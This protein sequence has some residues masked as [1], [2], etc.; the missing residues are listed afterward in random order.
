M[1][2]LLITG[3]A[4]VALSTTA[5]AGSCPSLVHKID[6]ALKTAQLSDADKASIMVM[7]NQGEEQH[8]A[9]QHAESVATLNAALQKLGM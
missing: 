2:K 9:G 3:A 6:E 7:R 1:K 8:K 4:I 5:I